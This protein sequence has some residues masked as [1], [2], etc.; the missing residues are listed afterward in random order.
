VPRSPFWQSKSA[1]VFKKRSD[2]PIGP[3]FERG[4]LEKHTPKAVGIQHAGPPRQARSGLAIPTR[5]SGDPPEIGLGTQLEASWR[6][7]HHII[8]DQRKCSSRSDTE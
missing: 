5:D 2:G 1:P 6:S 7:F 3:K 4:D 8:L